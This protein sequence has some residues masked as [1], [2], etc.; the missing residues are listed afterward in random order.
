[1]SVLLALV[2]AASVYG[3]PAKTAEAR[4]AD[5]NQIVCRYYPSGTGIVRK[6]CSTKRE[7]EERSALQRREIRELQQRSYQAGL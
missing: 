2:A 4:K 5:Q 3:E 1:M 6:I 7:H